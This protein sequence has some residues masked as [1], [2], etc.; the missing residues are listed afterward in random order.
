MCRICN[1]PQFSDVDVC[2]WCS[3]VMYRHNIRDYNYKPRLTFFGDTKKPMFGFELE[4]ELLSRDSSYESN[5]KKIASIGIESFPENFLCA[6][7]DGSL[8]QGCEYVSQPF[9]IEWMNEHR[10]KF[11]AFFENIKQIGMGRSSRTGL[12]IG[13][14]KPDFQLVNKKKMFLLMNKFY[15]PSSRKKTL[16]HYISKRYSDRYAKVERIEDEESLDYHVQQR[17]KYNALNT[18]KEGYVE[19]RSFDT[20]MTTNEL[21]ARVQLIDVFHRLSLRMSVQNML[22]WDIDLFHDKVNE[23]ALKS[24]YHELLEEI[25]KWKESV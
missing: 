24:E 8:E 11:D 9:N 15:D 18:G 23:Y 21:F 22:K 3:M 13:F 17:N 19:F 16:I 2:E 4:T 14:S 25:L 20:V 12:H 5:K 10:D 6:K 7:R 1:L